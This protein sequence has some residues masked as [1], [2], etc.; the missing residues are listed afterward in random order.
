M[1]VLPSNRSAA[2]AKV[3]RADPNV[4]A[5][6]VRAFEAQLRGD[7]VR[8]GDAAYDE[9]RALYNAMI[10]KRPL[11]IAR[12]VDVADV[13]V[14][15]AFARDHGLPLAVRGGGHSGGGLSSVDD[16]V[17]LDLSGL[18]GVRIDAEARTA[19]VE[20]GATWGKVD[21]ASHAFGLAVPNGL[22]STT[23]VGGLT[24]GGGLGHL[25]R[26][27]GLTIDNLL[28]VDVVLA[29]GRLVTANAHEHRDL[30]WAVRGGGGNFG[31]VTSFL[32]RLHPVHTVVGGPT[33]WPLEDAADVMRWYRDFI[34]EA[35][36]DLNGFFAFLT[37]PAVPRFPEHLHGR[38]VC[39]VVWCYSGPPERAADV[40][41]PVAAFGTPLLHGVHDMPF[42][43][44]QSASDGLHPAG[45]Q[46]Y[47]RADFVD[48]LSDAAIA[49]HALHGP[50]MPTMLSTMHLYPIDGA[51][52]DVAT[53]ATPWSYRSA[54]W[55]QVV[56]G[57]DPDPANAGV[58][59]AWAKAYHDALHPHSAGGAYV[60]MM[61]DEGQERVRA[62]YRDNYARLARVKA[63]YD[64]R[65]LFR[66]NQNI[67]PEG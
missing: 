28:E 10:D 37:V 30:F 21:H 11:L 3:A 42:P 7:L 54:N 14:T 39:G 66:V 52:H 23:G 29:D 35:P 20:G 67:A 15:V 45:H 18:N 59:E 22:I 24:L 36:R 65:N 46:W 63:A 32:F 57:V 4:L 41:A 31:V 34:R 25:T 6:A 64:P 56:V 1:S 51:A 50:T 60:N 47:W 55:A 58:I 9:A 43:V 13:I 38:K 62:S 8:R 2:R 48:E 40:F 16:G 19:R 33:L 49:A 12:C 53:D 17:L 5:K 27:H 44:L 26:R 61:M